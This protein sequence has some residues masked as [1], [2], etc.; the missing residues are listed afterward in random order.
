MIA[1]FEKTRKNAPRRN[2]DEM[3]AIRSRKCKLNKSNRPQRAQ[4][5]TL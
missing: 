5:E 1:N 3:E 2:A 4:W